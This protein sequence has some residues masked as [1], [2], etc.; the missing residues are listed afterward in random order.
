MRPLPLADAEWRL[1]YDEGV[2]WPGCFGRARQENWEMSRMLSHIMQSHGIPGQLAI[3]LLASGYPAFPAGKRKAGLRVASREMR[4]HGAGPHPEATP[5]DPLKR[6][7][8]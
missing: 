3:K 4:Q 1:K 5:G 8:Q 2:P 7:T 6:Q